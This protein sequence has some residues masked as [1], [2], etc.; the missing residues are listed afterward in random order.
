MSSEDLAYLAGLFDGEGCIHGR[1]CNKEGHPTILIN[2]SQKRTEI[3][4]WIK[5]LLRMGRVSTSSQVK[6]W[7]ISSKEDI[8]RFINLIL[9]YCKIKKRELIIGQKLIDLIGDSG[10]HCNFDNHRERMVF[11]NQLKM[12]KKGGDVSC[13]STA[14]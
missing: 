10:Q 9:P 11:F 14:I 6:S 1:I 4:Y 2:I 12:L 13:V 3:L 8:E 7:R 5:S